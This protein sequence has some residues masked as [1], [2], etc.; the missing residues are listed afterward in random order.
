MAAMLERNGKDGKPTPSNVP[1]R[2][3]IRC[4]H[5]GCETSYTISYTDDEHYVRGS[6]MNVDK[7]R[8]TAT[9][10]VR[11]EHSAHSTKIYLWKGPERCWLEADSLAA[12]AAL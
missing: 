6:E 9:D 8:R 12:R 5:D 1:P 3:L 7:M 11:N 10:L 2:E 4:P